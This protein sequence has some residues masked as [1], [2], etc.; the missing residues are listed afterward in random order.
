MR[1]EFGRQPIEQFRVRR[2]R[3]HVAEIAGRFDDPLAE[4]IVPDAVN[5]GA[6]CKRVARIGD[7]FGQRRAA[8]RFRIDGEARFET[9]N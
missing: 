8:L 9:F 4:M 5:D 3:A 1:E 7:P 6:P 2:Q